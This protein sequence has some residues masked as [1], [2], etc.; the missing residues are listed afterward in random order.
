MFF[1]FWIIFFLFGLKSLNAEIL[2][3]KFELTFTPEKELLSGKAQFLVDKEG[4]YSF[5]GKEI[6]IFKITQGEKNLN[7]Y[8][9][10]KEG[11]FKVYV[12]DTKIP[13]VIL[14]ERE[15]SFKKS[16][17]L[18]IYDKYLP[19]PDKPIP[20]EL[21]FKNYSSIKNFLIIPYEEVE[22]SSE[23]SVVF[24]Y[25]RPLKVP[26]PLVVAF[27]LRKKIISLNVNDKEILF[28]FDQSYPDAKWELK[29][30][31]LKNRL[32]KF[33]KDILKIP[34]KKLFVFVTFSEEK[35]YP[36]SVFLRR[37]T[38][39]DIPCDSF[40]PLLVE[41]IF[42]YELNLS[43]SLL[44]K[45]FKIYFGVYKFSKDKIEFRRALLLNDNL[46]SKIFF[47]FYEH[48]ERGSGEENFDKALKSYYET[49]LSNSSSVKPFR[50]FLQDL[51][52]IENVEVENFQRVFLKVENFE[53]I[54]TD[55]KEKY[56]LKFLLTRE[57]DYRPLKIKV[58]I[59]SP[60]ITKEEIISFEGDKEVYEISF[61]EKP[62]EIIFDP[63]YKIFRTLTFKELSMS[64]KTLSEVKFR[65]YLPNKENYTLYREIIEKFRH[66]ISVIS[67]SQPRLEALPREN[68]L[69][70]HGAPLGYHQH[71]PEEGFFFKILPHP[72]S[73]AHF[74]AFIKASST[75]EIADFLKVEDSIKDYS[76]FHTKGKKILYKREKEPSH[77]GI[78]IE[79]SAKRVYGTKPT[80]FK[81]LEEILPELLAS[82]IILIG[83]NHENYS[84]HLFQLEVIKALYNYYPQL[85]IGLEMVQ[86]PFQEYLD[87]FIE[88]KID[89][90]TLLKEIEY[91]ERWRFD[92]RLYRDIFLFAREKKIKLLALDIKGEIVKKVFKEGLSKLLE[93][94]KLHLPE[95]DLFRP[96]YR[97]YLERIYQKH[98]FKDNETN[99]EYFYQ[100]QVLRDEHMAERAVE[101]LKKNP[102]Y[103]MVILVG[104][105]HLEYGYGIPASLKRRNFYNFKSIIL[106][107]LE[108][109]NPP[110]GDYWFFPD[111]EKNFEPSPKLGVILEEIHDTKE[112]GLR[113]KEVLKE[114]LAERAGLKA[115]DVL[116]KIDEDVL[117]KVSDLLLHL[118]FKNKGDIIKLEVLREGRQTII[119]IKI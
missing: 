41:E 13:L 90:K 59:V 24:K 109:I 101:F 119:E 12:K 55:G 2:S 8:P 99:F 111:F 31:E 73:Q 30:K 89:E 105:G 108:R 36:L 45:A 72:L 16:P 104:R 70:F 14:F 10:E 25:I 4:F 58:K 53:L 34:N 84:H 103:K 77:R 65:V 86:V 83:E 98:G 6:K 9:D 75:R 38:L 23:D 43:D 68:I 57:G 102:S 107:E 95:L 110:L 22:P 47:Y 106:G 39:K 115:G 96:E 63:E 50:L 91:F 26:P 49:F 79:F 62:E 46:D 19:F 11:F 97:N 116:L 112:G 40:F 51:L 117:K 81:T 17:F 80:E 20:F 78:K 54:P 44:L 71:L 18:R 32:L 114:S 28:Y 35:V 88:G 3:A 60:R 76:E 27:N 52:K 56:K 92:Y 37:D 67:Y 64:W 66:N 29:E 15:V 21:E 93:E 118:T 87:K 1:L 69:I 94:E 5:S 82:Q 113:V 74:L 85:V 61:S 33:D 42:K 7:I 100:A 48:L